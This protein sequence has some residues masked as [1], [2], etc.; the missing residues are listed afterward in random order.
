MEAVCPLL[1]PTLGD[2][3]RVIAKDGFLVEIALSQADASAAANVDG[4]IKLHF[5][6]PIFGTGAIVGGGRAKARGDALSEVDL[7]EDCVSFCTRLQSSASL[8]L[9]HN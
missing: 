3:D 5:P 9:R 8:S 4:G 7:P 2:G 1:D 6:L